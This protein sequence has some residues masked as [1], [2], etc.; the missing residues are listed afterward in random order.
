MKI[1]LFFRCMVS[2]AVGLFVAIT[3]SFAIMAI[4]YDLTLTEI[5]D[6][7]AK[8]SI[9]IAIAYLIMIPLAYFE[10]IKSAKS[11]KD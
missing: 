1:K 2:V 6:G 9:G 10:Q 4:I 7:V 5:L 8:Y 3:I 11:D